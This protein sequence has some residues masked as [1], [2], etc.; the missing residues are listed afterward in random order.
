[1]TWP[2]PNWVVEA[3]ILTM[4]KQDGTQEGVEKATEYAGVDGV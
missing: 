1:M 3:A 4:K 2:L